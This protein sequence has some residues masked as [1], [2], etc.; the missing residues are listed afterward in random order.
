MTV[1]SLTNFG[2]PGETP[3]AKMRRLAREAA[4]RLESEERTKAALLLQEKEY[5]RLEVMSRAKELFVPVMEKIKEAAN[6]GQTFYNHRY[7]HENETTRWEA[8]AVAKEA[9]SHG[10]KAQFKSEESDMGDSAAPCWTT[11][12]W[13]E[14]DWSE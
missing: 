2:V 13:L 3:A 7:W 9:K 8:Q 6:N 4:E 11:F 10:F 1:N 12:Y 5:K 14:I